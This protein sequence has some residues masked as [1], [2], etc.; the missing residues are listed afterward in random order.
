MITL[1]KFSNTEFSVF[2]DSQTYSGSINVVAGILLSMGV[3][4]DEIEA[5]IGDM[6]NKDH[7][8]AEFG[9]NKTFIFS[10][11]FNKAA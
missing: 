10:H 6:R 2:N 7:N 11:N 5:A 8:T 9:I 1:F 3:Y 4:E